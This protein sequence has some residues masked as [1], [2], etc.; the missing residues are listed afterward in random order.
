MTTN[1]NLFLISLSA[2]AAA[3]KSKLDKVFFGRAARM[4]Y[5]SCRM[6][7]YLCFGHSQHLSAFQQL[8]S[9]L[10]IVNNVQWVEINGAQYTIYELDLVRWLRLYGEIHESLL[11][12]NALF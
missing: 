7:V 4:A 5:S 6:E 8:L 3:R 12:N 10:L 9:W 1:L 2:A 11:T